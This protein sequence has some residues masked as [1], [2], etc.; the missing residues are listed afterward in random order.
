MKF[1][2]LSQEVLV[3][4]SQQNV[5]FDKAG[6]TPGRRRLHREQVEHVPVG[7]VIQAP[8]SALR[9]EGQSSRLS[10]SLGPPFPLLEVMKM[11]T[12][13]EYCRETPRERD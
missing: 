1:A 6:L 12:K 4:K 2:E 9:T 13:N 8:P 11:K 10:Y 3:T 5:H 7:D